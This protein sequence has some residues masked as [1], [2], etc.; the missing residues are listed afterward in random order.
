[1][2][3]PEP[4][5]INS[6]EDQFSFTSPEI[7]NFIE[8]CF[9]MD[10]SERASCVDLIEHSYFD[11]KFLVMFERTNDELKKRDRKERHKELREKQQSRQTIYQVLPQLTGINESSSQTPVHHNNHMNYYHN[12]H[13]TK[14][15]KYVSQNQKKSNNLPNI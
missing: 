10:P 12:H 2:V 5:A 8:C 7:L 11:K 4:D 3:I 15:K 14:N 1:M 13:H 6:L 9:L